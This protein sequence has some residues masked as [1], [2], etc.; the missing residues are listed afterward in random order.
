MAIFRFFKMAAAAILDFRN[1]EFL[2]VGCVT[3]VK[4]RH[5]SKFRRNRSDRGRDIKN[6]EFQYYASLARKCLFTPFLG[7]FGHIP[8]NDVTRRPNPKTTV[9]NGLNHVI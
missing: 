9:L 7:F 8:P 3:N 6:Y 2:T 5:R 1:F 4:L